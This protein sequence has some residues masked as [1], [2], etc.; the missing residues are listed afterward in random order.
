MKPDEKNKTLQIGDYE[1]KPGEHRT[2]ELPL[3]AMVTHNDVEMT[4]HV[5]SGR[6]AGPVLFVNAAIHGDELNGVE[7]IRRLLKQRQLNRLS[8]T[9]I[10]IPIVNVYGFLNNSRYLPDGRDLNRSF[11]GSSKGSLAARIANTFFNE[12]VKTST[13]GIDLHTGARHR[14]NLPQ[15]RADL[16]N[17]EVK[18]MASA[19]DVPVIIDSKIRDGSLRQMGDDANVPVLL[20]E[21]GEALRFDELSIRAGVRG[22]INVMR[23]LKML[24]HKKHRILNKKPIIS[25]NTTWVRAP[26][27][28]ILRALVPLGA[29]VMKD[30][31]LGVIADPLGASEYHVIAHDEGIVIGR[32]YMPLVHEG[33]ALFHLAHYDAK[34]E[35]VYSQ[36]EAFQERYEPELNPDAP[37]DP[38][39]APIQ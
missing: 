22:I 4:V 14:A 27:S 15:L 37:F 33:E 18:R 39:N 26:H 35:K 6:K 10:A 3:A 29:R 32:T 38:H 11:P 24:P 25:R 34:S 1:I 5:V 17:D 28:G 20:Y 7:V 19:F 23:E 12:I 9:L 36:L 13:H 8:G 31:V 2:I 16:S 21:A 30:D